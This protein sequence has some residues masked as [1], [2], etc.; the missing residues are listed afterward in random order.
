MQLRFL[1]DE[2]T[3]HRLKS[4][5]SKS[6]HDVKR[7]ATLHLLHLRFRIIII[8]QVGRRFATRATSSLY[9]FHISDPVYADFYNLGYRSCYYWTLSI[10]EPTAARR[11]AYETARDTLYDGIGVIG[12][13][14]RP[15]RSPP[16]FRTWRAN[17]PT[18]TGPT[19]TR[20]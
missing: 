11:D 3:E 8:L 18:I 14:S 4:E 17:T 16:S 15:T 13:G 10:G 19:N 7:V 1:L 5:L 9:Q 6:G 12:P 2:D 20:N